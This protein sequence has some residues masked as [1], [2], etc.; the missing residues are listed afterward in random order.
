MNM[1]FSLLFPTYCIGCKKKGNHLCTLCIEKAPR[2]KPSSHGWIY[3]VFAYKGVI[4]SLIHRLKYKKDRDV[5]CMAPYLQESLEELL[6]EH[7]D[8]ISQK[9]VLV[10]V[11]LFS[12]R[13]KERGYNQAQIIA[14]AIQK[15]RVENWLYKKKET[16][17]QSK[18]KTK[19]E[20]IQNIRGV[21]SVRGGIEK[22]TTV[23][24]IDDVYT[25]GATLTEARTTLEEKGI[26]HIYALTLAH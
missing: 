3:S 17:P 20:R 16:L 14:E 21:F 2:A 24:L 8:F 11:P 25:T 26:R 18:M 12:K 23:V 13:E 6:L 9:V 7:A 4:R 10:P 19:D 15:Y 5:S 22:D 1:F